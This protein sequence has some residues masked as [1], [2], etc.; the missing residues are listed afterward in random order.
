MQ[1]SGDIQSKL[2]CR[3]LSAHTLSFLL[4][5]FNDNTVTTQMGNI[6]ILLQRFKTYED[7]L[8]QDAN[9]SSSKW[10]NV[11]SIS[12]G[13]YG[14]EVS[15]VEEE[16]VLS[17]EAAELSLVQTQTL[18]RVTAPGVWSDRKISIHL[19]L[20]SIQFIGKC[21]KYIH[22]RICQ[23]PIDKSKTVVT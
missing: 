11:G 15:T 7:I 17:T 5:T 23:Q 10:D 19:K 8:S 9:I 13:S 14:I 18:E 16:V 2:T 12:H 3:P 20:L 4:N 22:S 21:L 1:C 6:L